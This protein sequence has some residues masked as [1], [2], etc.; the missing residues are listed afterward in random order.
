ML[1]LDL[2]RLKTLFVRENLFVKESLK[3]LVFLKNFFKNNKK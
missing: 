3:G 2:I 1:L